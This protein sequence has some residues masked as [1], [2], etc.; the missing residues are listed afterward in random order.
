MRV[1]RRVVFAVAG[2]ILAAFALTACGGGGSTASSNAAG[3]LNVGMPNGPQTDNNNPFLSSSAGASLGY[4][5]MIFEPLTMWNSAKPADK[6][7]PW[8]ATDWSWSADY[9]TLNLTTR[10]NVKW[11]DGQAFSADDVAFTFNLLKSTP[12]LNNNGIQFGDITAA[13]S[14]KLTVTFPTPQFVNQVKILSDIPIVAKHQWSTISDPATDPIKTPVGTGP[15]TLKSFTPQ[16]ITLD[17][18]DSYWQDLPKVKEIRYTSYTDNNAQTTALATGACEW[19]FVFIPN[20]KAVYTSKDPAHYQIYFPPSLGVHGL[21]FNTQK[22]PFNDPALR[23]AISMVINRD[24]IFNQG[25][26]GYFYPA[27]TSPTGIPTPAG[28]SFIS[29][30]YKGQTVKVDVDGA[31]AKLTSAGYKLD[32]TTL[33]D[34][35]G[36]PVTLTLTDPAGWSDYQTDLEIIKDNLS[37]IGIAATVDKANQDTWTKDIDTG[38]FDA[39]MHWTDSGATPYQMYASIMD[40]ALYKPVGTP[41]VNGNYG[42]FQNQDATNALNTY[43]NATDD[44]SR[45]TALNQI[46]KIMVDQMPMVPTSAANVGGEYSTKNWTGWPSTSDEY[47]PGQPTLINALD[48]VLHLRPAS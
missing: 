34:K 33:K 43:V 39:A 47:A 12:A 19:S 28:E 20:Y 26:A 37:K 18:R 32:G 22:A 21:W 42:R 23:Q 10:D 40:G 7:K 8:L 48:I 45:S 17:V 6:A 46:Q 25:E 14:N 2:S 41:G 29:P 38:N 1:S 5:R 30:D 13:G 16:T 3:V 36:K 27:V 44:A 31:K 24:D 15:Y 4:R 35:D 9:K 11:S